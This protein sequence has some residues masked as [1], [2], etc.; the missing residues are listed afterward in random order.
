MEILKE[1]VTVE[2]KVHEIVNKM[3]CDAE[4][5]FMNWAQANV[6][7]RDIEKPTIVYVL[8]PAGKLDFS[9][10]RVKDY[11]ETQIGFLAP[12]DFDF[13]GH[14]NDNIVEQM[15]RLAILF[16][17]VL[18]LSEYFELI[19]GNVSYQ[20]VYDYLDQ[21]V[22]GIVITLKLKEV[23]GVVICDDEIARVMEKT[24]DDTSTEGSDSDTK[25]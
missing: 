21:N 23:N 20:V 3:P 4:Y 7:I 6:A 24:S 14:E 17:K 1:Y 9:Y 18:N 8:P 2:Q 16:V 12:T 5:L 10:A 13:D 11:P 19:E 25:L 22:T 15:K